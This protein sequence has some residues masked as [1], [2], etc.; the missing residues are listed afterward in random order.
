MVLGN[1]YP[2]FVLSDFELLILE[3]H[4]LELSLNLAFN[5]GLRWQQWHMDRLGEGKMFG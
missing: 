5:L 3:C 4:A 1:M 2:C